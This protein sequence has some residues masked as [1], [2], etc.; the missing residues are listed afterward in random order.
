MTI[1]IST[2]PTAHLAAEPPTR[3][4]AAGPGDLTTSW[5]N[6]LSLWP[7]GLGV[8]LGI[9]GIIII[10]LSIGGWLYKSRHGG[11]KT[12]KSLPWAMLVIGLVCASP[13]WIIPIILTVANVLFRICAGIIE[14]F[15][16]LIGS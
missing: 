4:S 13:Q 9:I 1:G 14:G 3:V 6:F 12:F 15:F 10:V 11:G 7:N 16:R 2:T 5:N 8:A